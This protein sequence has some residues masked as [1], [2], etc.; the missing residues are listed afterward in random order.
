MRHCLASEESFQLQ[1][2]KFFKA[3]KSAVHKSFKKVRVGTR[4]IEDKDIGELLNEQAKLKKSLKDNH[5]KIFQKQSLELEEKISEKI[6]DRNA[7][8]VKEYVDS[9]FFDGKFSPIGM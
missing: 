1:C 2:D 4:I 8:I 9:M 5:S 6:A 3:L 7:K